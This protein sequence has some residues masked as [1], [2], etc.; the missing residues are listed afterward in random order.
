MFLLLFLMYYVKHL[1]LY[2]GSIIRE[3][4]YITF[5]INNRHDRLLKV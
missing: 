5:S 1:N 2:T 3:K 4:H